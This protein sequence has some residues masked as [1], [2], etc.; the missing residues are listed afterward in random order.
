MCFVD[1]VLVTVVGLVGCLLVILLGYCLAVC[2][3]FGFV[4]GNVCFGCW[5]LYLIVL[6]ISTY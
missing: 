6:M 5:F 3:D 4:V 1:L 2:L